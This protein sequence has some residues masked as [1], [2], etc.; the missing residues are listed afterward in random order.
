MSKLSAQDAEAMFGN[1][2]LVEERSREV[3]LLAERL[4]P[5][6]HAG[7]HI[8]MYCVCVCVWL[9]L[10]SVFVSDIVCACFVCMLCVY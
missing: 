5:Y 4:F 10:P 2:S 7:P 3:C 8:A 6:R 9:V 1:I